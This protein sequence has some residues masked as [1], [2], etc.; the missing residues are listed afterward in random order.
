MCEPPS[1]AVK[2]RY[3]RYLHNIESIDIKID[4][5]DSMVFFLSFKFIV[6]KLKKVSFTEFTISPNNQ[7]LIS[8]YISINFWLIFLFLLDFGIAAL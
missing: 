4:V 7:Q 2:Y 6:W 5:F 3:Y 1:D 8:V